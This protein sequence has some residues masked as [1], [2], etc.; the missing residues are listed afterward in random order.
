M[1]RPFRRR[2]AS[3]PTQ[4]VV[5]EQGDKHC[6]FDADDD[7]GVGQIKQL[8]NLRGGCE[9]MEVKSRVGRLIA[10]VALVPFA[11]FWVMGVTRGTWAS[12]TYNATHPYAIT[13]KGGTTLYFAEW[14]GW[15]LEHA[16]WIFFG[17]LFAIFVCEWMARRQGWP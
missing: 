7:S 3:A 2:D 15:F 4:L 8:M 11:V 14:P 16:L 10:V 9:M 6:R 13:F 12:H 1:L 17:L 5:S